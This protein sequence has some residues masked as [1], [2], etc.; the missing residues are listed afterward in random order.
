M[1]KSIVHVR[2]ITSKNFGEDLKSGHD[3]HGASLLV[4]IMALNLMFYSG[5]GYSYPFVPL[6]PFRSLVVYC[7]SDLCGF[8]YVVLRSVYPTLLCFQ[9]RVVAVSIACDS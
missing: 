4:I 5:R 6:L 9:Y 8:Y 2:F 7:Y 3:V 1:Q